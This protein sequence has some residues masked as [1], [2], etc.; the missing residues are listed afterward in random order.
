MPDTERGTFQI[1]ERCS[2]CCN[3]CLGQPSVKHWGPFVPAGSVGK[4]C[5]DCIEARREESLAGQEPRPVGIPTD[6]ATAEWIDLEDILIKPKT[7]SGPT[8]R[9]QVKYRRPT[10]LPPT[11][12]D[13][14]EV[15][16]KIGDNKYWE[17]GPFIDPDL[18]GANPAYARADAMLFLRY[19]FEPHG[20]IAGE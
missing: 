7:G 6:I 5:A 20:K 1:N 14:G 15:R 2:D 4:F 19:R 17:G 12:D 9:V 11:F 3:P 8:I 13:G 10:A 18:F 16:L